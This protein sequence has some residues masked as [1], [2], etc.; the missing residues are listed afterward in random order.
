[1]AKRFL[2][3]IKQDDATIAPLSEK[4]IQE[5]GALLSGAF[6]GEMDE[7]S[8][9]PFS[10]TLRLNSE[11]G[12]FPDHELLNIALL[13]KERL[14]TNIPRSYEKRF[15]P[16]IALISSSQEFIDDFISIYGGILDLV[17]IRLSVEQIKEIDIKRTSDKRLEITFKEPFPI[18]QALCDL[19][20]KCSTKCPQDA[21]SPDLII[22]FSRCDFCKGCVDACERGAIDLHRIT[23]KG[24]ILDEIIVKRDI[25]DILPEFPFDIYVHDE[26]EGLFKK[27]GTFSIEEGII[28]NVEYCSFDPRLKVGCKRCISFCKNNAIKTDE[29]GIRIEYESCI[30]CGNCVSA[31]PTGGMELSR[32]RDE[33]FLRYFKG[34]KVRKKR[35]VIGHEKELRDL[36]WKSLDLR[37][38]DTFFLEHPNPFSL[39][40]FHFLVLFGSGFNRIFILKEDEKLES[41]PPIF[42]EISFFNEL[43]KKIKGDEGYVSILNRKGLIKRFKEDDEK[44]K[45]SPFGLLSTPFEGRRGAFREMLKTVFSKIQ[46]PRERIETDVFSGLSLSDSCSL[47][48]SCLNVCYQGAL[49]TNEKELSISFTEINCTNC[50]ACLEICPE[51]AISLDEGLFLSRDIFKEKVLLRDEPVKCKR[52]GKVFS[53]KR[54][55]EKA[56]GILKKSGIYDQRMLSALYLCEDCRV[57]SMFEEILK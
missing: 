34:L 10:P 12:D 18:D 40:H 53:N 22:D 15:E 35:I 48:L 8:S 47:C 4:E 3:L 19:C 54:S 2:S 57:R 24:V 13:E 20:R 25:R 49:K 44:G 26:L 52:C 37:F 1:M 33:S 32:F 43:I 9:T 42:K 28:H 31:C 30:E 14:S 39:N 16:E 41:E 6:S 50:R 45:E 11:L 5:K 36:W 55:F 56:I 29:K 23:E 46:K 27:I 21:I 51:N 17:P 38:K 7:N